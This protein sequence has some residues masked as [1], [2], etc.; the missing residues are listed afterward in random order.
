MERDLIG[1]TLAGRY[2]VE[3]F[4]D[5]G[6]MASVYRVLDLQNNTPLAVKMLKPDLAE[7]TVFLRRFG[8]EA[9]VLQRLEHPNIVH[10]Y[11]LESL[12]GHA[13]LLL[14]YIDGITLR[15]RIFE[16]GGALPIKEIHSWLKPVCAALHY[17]HQLGIYHCDVKPA[18]I[19]VTRQGRVVLSDFGIARSAG[20]TLATMSMPGTPEFMAPEQWLGH[21]LD[22]RTDLYALGVTLYSMMTG[23]E[24]PFC[25]ESPQSEGDRYARI[26]WEQLFLPP[27]SPRLYNPAIGE[28]LASMVA[29]ALAKNPV[30]RFQTAADF[31]RAFEE[32][33]LASTT[34]TGSPAPVP[35]KIA[36]PSI[37]TKARGVA[38]PKLVRSTRLKW[39]IFTIVA[40]VILVVTLVLTMASGSGS[41][42]VNLKDGM[43]MVYMP[44]GEF[45]MG[46][47]ESD[48]VKLLSEPTP[49]GLADYE[50]RVRAMQPQHRVYLDAYWMYQTEVTNGMYVQCVAAGVCQPPIQNGSYTRDSYYDNP[51]YTNY[52]VIYVDWY[53]ANTY[54]GW[55]GGHL[56]SEAEWEKAAR[57]TDGRTYPW[58]DQ[59]PAGD[60]L[61]FCDKNCEFSFKDSN[62][63]DGYEDTAPVGS[64][65]QGASE[66]GA[67]DMAGNVWEWV[68]DWYS[69]TYYIG[70]PSENPQGPASG[71]YRVLRGGSCYNESFYLR[72]SN[73]N[74]GNP[75]NRYSYNGFRCAR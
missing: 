47:T 58:R 67:L 26:Q 30:D 45:L 9:L 68:A 1:Q 23:G 73:R 41:T 38:A 16:V 61:N 19:M 54:C 60:L 55:A 48:G 2:R 69:E 13:C 7:D 11:G 27:P 42:Q 10:Y 46:I 64:Y 62:V 15:R 37:R 53:Q 8:R 3:Q 72:S 14:E 28:G 57:G 34:E 29:K 40:G 4:I 71:E 25:G 63:N 17:A 65:P 51:T 6:G 49:V 50:S 20:G 36:S 70:S 56:P 5:Q 44:A 18:N 66:Y 35:T 52:P 32:N 31:Y 39:G 12:N 24:R 43:R 75:D 59:P 74:R 22:A 21:N 33:R